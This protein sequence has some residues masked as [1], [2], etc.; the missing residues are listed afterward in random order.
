[1]RPEDKV[2]NNQYRKSAV[3]GKMRLQKEFFRSE[4][5]KSIAFIRQHLT[6]I[7]GEVQEEDCEQALAYHEGMLPYL[8]D[9]RKELSKHA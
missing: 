6:W 2:G 3:D 9:L 8:E 7:E 4:A 5:E 1:M